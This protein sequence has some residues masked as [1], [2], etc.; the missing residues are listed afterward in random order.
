M[1]VEE[2]VF[3]RP[4]VFLQ[5]GN[6]RHFHRSSLDALTESGDLF[7]SRQQCGCDG[8]LRLIT[9]A[10]TLISK[11]TVS[12]LLVYY[13]VFPDRAVI[14]QTTL[15]ASHFYK[16]PFPL[17]IVGISVEPTMRKS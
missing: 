13:I 1:A 16:I 14:K 5:C 9:H 12:F 11:T 2:W 6:P 10:P 7:H 3:A 15:V 4:C 8:E 17:Q